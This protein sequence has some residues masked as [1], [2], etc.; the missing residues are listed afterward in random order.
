MSRFVVTGCLLLLATLLSPES[1]AQQAKSPD[2]PIEDK[3][4]L[5]I[6]V[7]KFADPKI[8]T[9]RFSAKDAKDFADF[10][11]EKGHF[12]RD[13]V[14]LLCD[15][16]ATYENIKMAIGDRW[17]PQRALSNDL[18][19]IYASTHGSPKEID[20][21]KDNWLIAH[22]TKIGEFY[23]T[24]I[25]L[26]DLASTVKE[27]TGCDRIVI[28]LDACNSGAA[29]AGGGKGLVRGANFDISSLAGQGEIILSSSSSDQRSWESKR[30]ENGV[31]TRKLIEALNI[32]GAS[33]PLTQAYDS[34]RSQVEAEVR[35][36]R[37]ASQTPV[38]HKNW[39][40]KELA[41]LAPP[42]RPR[43]TEPSQLASP[44][45][46]GSAGAEL[47][48]QGKQMYQKKD[49][50]GAFE[51]FTR[52]IEAGNASALNELG[53]LYSE[54]NGVPRDDAKAVELY[55]KAAALNDP[56]A[57]TNLGLRFLQ[58]RGVPKDETKALEYLKRAAEL[59]NSTALYSLG[60]CY[61][62]G[63]GVTTDMTK[64]L[65]YYRKAA[66]QNYSG[67]YNNLGSAYL[68]GR[69]VTRDK[70][71]A[72]RLF[73]KAAELDNLRSME[74]LGSIYS[75]GGDGIEKD[76]EEAA[77]WYKKAAE[78]GSSS[79]QVSVGLAYWNGTGLPK[80][81]EKAAYW[82]KKAADQG[83]PAG[84][85]NLGTCYKFGNGMPKDMHKAIELYER[86]ANMGYALAQYLLACAYINGDGVK[87]D[88]E[89]A[90]EW[91][92]KSAELGNDSGQNLLGTLYESGKGVPR[93][94]TSAVKW[95]L[96]AAEQGNTLAKN[97][98]KRLGL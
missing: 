69:G 44:M 68:Q 72:A 18:V 47:C 37:Q 77:S 36:D 78:K 73:K 35:F 8:P 34:L 93:D 96:K 23:T 3:W 81:Y 71:E 46:G 86:S 38:L 85:N 28:I 5:V 30:Y 32:V 45:P 42:V 97:N 79:A 15:E 17:L 33:T 21:G 4:A 14:L 53:V 9:L 26:R 10:L 65:E 31:F 25:R 50:K 91:S 89:K 87:K 29:Q 51:A 7:G 52:A 60:V 66:E 54:G 41:I 24:G 20:V 39:Q 12:A 49:Y 75:T 83:E 22:N 2:R 27:R 80:D 98:L 13:H 82:F 70:K 94:K 48:K 64:A 58:A 76:D 43:Q 56:P 95:Y 1:T 59:D 16:K 61:D 11:V 88:F 90:A 63:L 57:I 55:H 74:N 62:Q 40:G 6:G 92:R 19:L 67:A 84:F